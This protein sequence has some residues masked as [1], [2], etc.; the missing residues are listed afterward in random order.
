MDPVHGPRLVPPRHA[1]AREPV[2]DPA[3]AGRR[4]AAGVPRGRRTADPP[5]S[6]R[7]HV[8]ALR[9]HPADLPH[10]DH[11]LVGRVAALRFERR[12]A[13]RDS[14]HRHGRQDRAHA[15][16]S[17]PA[18]PRVRRR[19]HRLQRR[20]LA[21]HQRAAHAL[22]PRTQ[23]DLRHAEARAPGLVERSALQPRA[24]DQYGVAR[25]DSHRRVDTGDPGAPGGE[26]GHGVLLVRAPRPARA[27][28]A[29]AQ[30]LRG[31]PQ[32]DA[33][34]QARSLRRAGTRSRRSS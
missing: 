11:P 9:G 3:R 17:A 2:E 27:Q 4:L 26:A 18:R 30:A 21:G 32:R 28:V 33:G 20:L 5:Y 7:P 29:P 16:R 14:W 6:A 23:R 25:P 31:H 15:E 12:A 1:R 22:Q 10:V 19:S 13:R 8:D 24:P 34:R